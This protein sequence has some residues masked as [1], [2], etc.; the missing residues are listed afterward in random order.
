MICCRT[1]T[2]EFTGWQFLRFHA[3][4]ISILALGDPDGKGRCLT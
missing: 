2:L 3:A 1:E 4:H